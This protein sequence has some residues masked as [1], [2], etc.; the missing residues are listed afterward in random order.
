MKER[1]GLF[2]SRGK[3]LRERGRVS[4]GFRRDKES[5]E[6]FIEGGRV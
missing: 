6:D 4:V 5:I 2:L 1:G 3:K